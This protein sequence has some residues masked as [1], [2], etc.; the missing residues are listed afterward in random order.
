MTGPTVDGVT[1]R[2]TRGAATRRALVDAAI[3]VLRGQG[4]AGASARTIAERAGVNQALVFYHFGRSP[5]CCSPPST[6]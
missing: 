1:T 2:T 6:T 3:D 5:D 4:F